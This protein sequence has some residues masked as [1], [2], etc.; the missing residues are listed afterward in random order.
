MVLGIGKIPLIDDFKKAEEE[1][2]AFEMEMIEY[3]Q[4]AIIL[5]NRLVKAY[6]RSG[7]KM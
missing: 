3:Y 2:N 6:M 7:V 5:N 1:Y 4:Q